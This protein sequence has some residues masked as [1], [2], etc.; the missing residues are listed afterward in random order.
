MLRAAPTS[1]M[2]PSIEAEKVLTAFYAGYAL[3][4]S[5]RS[6]KGCEIERLENVGEIWALCFRKPPP[7]WRLF[8]KFIERD[9]F[10]ASAV[11]DRHQLAGSNYSR[12]ANAAIS[13]LNSRFP[14]LATHSGVTLGDYMTGPIM[15]LD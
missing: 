15:D 6:A 14:Q 2:F 5:L 10:V 13:D 11:Y 1:A 3:N 4:G 7:G 8:G 9:V 12:L